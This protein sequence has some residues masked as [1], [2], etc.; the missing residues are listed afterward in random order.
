MRGS[1]GETSACG[2]FQAER[3]ASAEGPEALEL[4]IQVGQ[5]VQNGKN[6]DQSDGDETRGLTGPLVNPWKE[7]G[8]YSDW[9][10]MRS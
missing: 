4:D 9:K 10:L 7:F 5:W 3:T 2:T 1:H 6:G 8:F